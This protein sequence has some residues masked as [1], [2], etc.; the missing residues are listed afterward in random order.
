MIEQ[1]KGRFQILC[2]SGGGVRGLYTI[3][4]L[5]ELE[6]KLSKDKGIHDYNIVK[7]FDMV[8][9]TSIG[10]ILALALAAGKNARSLQT[11]LDEKR[12]VI[13][14]QKKRRWWSQAKGV[15]FDAE[16]LAQIIE[17]EIGTIRLKNL[18]TRVIVPAVNGSKGLPKVFKTPHHEE[19]TWDGE[20]KVSDVALATSAAPTYFKAHS[21]SE[22]N[23]GLMLDGGLFANSPSFIA[24]HETTCSRFLGISSNSVHMLKVGTMG[25]TP[26]M[27]IGSKGEEGYLKGWG[28]GRGL[29]EMVMGVSEHWHNKMTEHYLEE[30]FVSLDDE[31][32]HDFNLADSSDD[33][34]EAL[35]LHA[36][37]RA[38]QATGQKNI[39]DFFQHEAKAPTFY[40]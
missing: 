2:L 25:T 20:R 6:D 10:G 35:K 23:M 28:F 24:Y 26:K 21:F 27:S 12:K 38:Q 31:N 32:I 30:R 1:E 15:A 22:E 16:I 3:S 7:H 40:N 37:D 19:F 5:A 29:L 36:N 33:T 34:A 8:A 17:T 4:V 14:P 9:G 39:M 18:G 11:L 13:F